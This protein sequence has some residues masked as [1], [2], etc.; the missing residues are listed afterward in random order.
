M[1]AES[2]QNGKLIIFDWEGTLGLRGGELVPGT[3]ATL[4]VLK[5]N[6]FDLAIATSMGTD[7]LLRLLEKHDLASFFSHLQT[8]EMGYPKPDPQMLVEVLAATAHS[9]NNAVM[10]GDCSYDLSMAES[11]HVTPIGVLT[12]S[13]NK[14]RLLAAAENATVL[15]TINDLP[16][17]FNLPASCL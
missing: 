11:A 12:G 16:R 10:V 3:R 9:A 1:S 17:Y 13:D 5:Q 15:D 6:G 8:S 4:D 7:G 2:C 14:E